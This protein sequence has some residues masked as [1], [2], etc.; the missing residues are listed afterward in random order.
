[1]TI[2]NSRTRVRAKREVAINLVEGY[3]TDL[4]AKLPGI[5]KTKPKDRTPDEKKAATRLGNLV[6]QKQILE[7]RIRTF[8]PCR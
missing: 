2:K 5:R 6:Q 1:M 4:E 8:A 3:I 7:E